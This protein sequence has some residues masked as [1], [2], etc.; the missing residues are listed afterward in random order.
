MNTRQLFLSIVAA[1]NA[2]TSP[3]AF[4]AMG[5]TLQEEIETYFPTSTTP[6]R[7]PRG[8]LPEVLRSQLNV[9]LLIED[10][11][12]YGSFVAANVRPQQNP[13]HV[14]GILW[15]DFGPGRLSRIGFVTRSQPN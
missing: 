4:E 8:R 11:R 14:E 13:A 3:H 7:V 10:P 5:E 1:H 6:Q 2:G 15:M 9:R 12:P